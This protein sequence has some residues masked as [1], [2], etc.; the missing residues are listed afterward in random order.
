MTPR[1][2]HLRKACPRGC[3]SMPPPQPTPR[4]RATPPRRARLVSLAAQRFLA[5]VLH[6]ARTV[7]EQQQQQSAAKL[8]EAG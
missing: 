5:E 3:R 7:L 4:T 2:L 8:K 1:R 6:E